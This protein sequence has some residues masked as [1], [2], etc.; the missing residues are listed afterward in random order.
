[1]LHSLVYLGSFSA[2]GSSAIVMWG[3]ETAFAQI[4][5][6]RVS[7]TH[8]SCEFPCIPNGH[9][10]GYLWALDAVQTQ[11]RLFNVLGAFQKGINFELW[12]FF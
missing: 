3:L 12:N 2:G 11:W 5:Y 1:M 9:V 7:K 6:V 8:E 10:S 4:V